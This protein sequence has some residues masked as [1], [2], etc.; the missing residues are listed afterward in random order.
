M[1]AVQQLLASLEEALESPLSLGILFPGTKLRT[2]AVYSP[3]VQARVS[4]P[5]LSALLGTSSQD[6]S[7]SSVKLEREWRVDQI[8]IFR[9]CFGFKML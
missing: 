9:N 8:L 2:G 3:V 6:P 5:P 1:L 7:P 4:A